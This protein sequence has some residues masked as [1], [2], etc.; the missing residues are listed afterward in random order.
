MLLHGEGT[1]EWLEP[2]GG[3]ALGV[4]SGGW[5][6]HQVE[7]PQGTGLVLLTD[8][9]FEGHSGLGNER[10]GEEG[11][12]EVARSHAALP[13]PAFVD[14]LIEEAAQRAQAHGGLTDDIAVV[15]VERTSR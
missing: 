5:E 8:G 4:H 12:L 14:A 7:W 9:L 10:L 2:P 1:V 15:R 3:P 13:G 6:Y 11:L